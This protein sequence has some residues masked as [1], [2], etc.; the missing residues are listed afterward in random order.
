MR[1]LWGS[2]GAAICLTSA[3]AC[4]HQRPAAVPTPAADSTETAAAVESLVLEIENHNWSDVVVYVAHDG[5]VTRLTLVTANT[6]TSLPIPP[7][8]VGSLGVVRLAVRRIGGT[9]S[10]ASEPISVRTGSTVRLTVE[11]RVATS[12]VAVW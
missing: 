5:L 11:S 10:Y 6:N 1:K 9:D 2:L 7:H 8:L 4:S 12:S 3:I